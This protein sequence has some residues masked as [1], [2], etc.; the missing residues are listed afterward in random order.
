MTPF[1]EACCMTLASKVEA[2]FGR[3]EDINNIKKRPT[4]AI[5]LGFR[6]WLKATPL[7]SWGRGLS[8]VQREGTHPPI[9]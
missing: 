1:D 7:G 9:Y 4:I 2:R 3:P 8:P 5:L 6:L